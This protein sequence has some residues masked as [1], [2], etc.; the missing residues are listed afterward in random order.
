ILL[1]GAGATVAESE[2]VF[3]GAALVAVTLDGDFE[4]RIVAQEIRGLAQSFASIGT[5]IRFVEV[6]EGIAD[7][8]VPELVH[9]W[10]RC[11]GSRAYNGDTRGGVGG[12]TRTAR[13]NGVGSG[14]RRSDL[15]GTLRGHGANVR[16]DGE[17]RCV[18][19]G[20]TQRRGL[21]FLN[22]RRG[23]L[24]RHGG[25]SSRWRRRSR[26]RSSRLGLFGTP[27]SKNSSNKR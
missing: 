16:S 23:R 17:L 10:L 11:R 12:A 6:E 20:P 15:G 26:R 8:R 9:R 25:L 21:A 27:E 24:E 18:S 2:V 19:G 7:V 5:D 13:C 14:G 1:R 22:G 3:G 4:L